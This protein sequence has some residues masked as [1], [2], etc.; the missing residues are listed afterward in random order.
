MSKSFVFFES[1][2]ESICNMPAK[3]RLEIYEAICHYA[4]YGDTIEMSPKAR[5]LFI[6]MK[7]NI[8]SSA[9][10]YRAAVENGKKGGR[11]KKTQTKPKQNLDA[12]ADV[13]SDF[14]VDVDV[15][16]ASAS[17]AV[18]IPAESPKA[19]F[20]AEAEEAE[21]ATGTTAQ[22]EYTDEQP[23]A[24]LPLLGGGEYPV[25]NRTVDSLRP[26]YPDMD[27]DAEIRRMGAWLRS[28]PKRKKHRE[29]IDGFISDW[30]NREW[31]K[32]RYGISAPAPSKTKEE[33]SAP[34]FNEDW[35]N[36]YDRAAN[37]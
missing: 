6:L 27:M 33:T 28:H 18:R 1:F 34:E 24:V 13:D 7:P 12:D 20:L 16:D 2:F 29:D 14:D 4:L 9:K 36:F 23:I 19:A 5:A 15:D 37:Q 32:I 26:I 10:R 35:Q 8:D 30:L 17:D 22:I 31:D 21:E 11:P 25:F 3:C